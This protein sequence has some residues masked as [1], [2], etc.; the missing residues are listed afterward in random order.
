MAAEAACFLSQFSGSPCSEVSAKLGFP[1]IVIVVVDVPVAACIPIGLTGAANSKVV[2][3]NRVIRRVCNIVA[4]EIAR[5]EREI[6]SKR[7][8]CGA[9]TRGKR[10]GAGTA[11]IGRIRPFAVKLVVWGIAHSPGSA[12]GRDPH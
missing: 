9:I 4:V 8:A 12:W 2:S 6:E 10:V 3:P 11:E 7:A 5:Q 1:N